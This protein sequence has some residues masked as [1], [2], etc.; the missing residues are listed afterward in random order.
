M[1]PW[2][3]KAK[4]VQVNEIIRLRQDTVSLNS[5][6]QE[7]EEDTKSFV[8]K[9]DTARL[10]DSKIAADNTRLCEDLESARRR[11]AD[12]C[13]H[14]EVSR[15]AA[16]AA[17]HE[18][19]SLQLELASYEKLTY[20]RHAAVNSSSEGTKREACS[21]GSL[22]EA[23]RQRWGRQLG[24]HQ[25]MLSQAET[26]SQHLSV[27]K[28]ERDLSRA[29]WET[30]REEFETLSKEHQIL[31]DDNMKVEEF[32]AEQ[33][34]K[35]KRLEQEIVDMGNQHVEA[36]KMHK[37]VEEVSKQRG[38]VLAMASRDLDRKRDLVYGAIGEFQSLIEAAKMERERNTSTLAAR[39]RDPSEMLPQSLARQAE[40]AYR[41]QRLNACLERTNLENELVDAESWTQ[42]LSH[43]KTVLS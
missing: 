12:L 13:Q 11:T 9:C 7:C 24:M 37:E 42:A 5:D 40:E 8:Q 2:D 38:C 33:R 18:A 23:E 20:E 26:A 30:A 36:C 16:D 3:S 19:Q 41:K 1:A 14:A 35:C 32:L 39:T 31:K 17:R 34:D 22:Q 21:V 6:I 28:A 4:K 15:A 43:H 29:R 10:C 25:E 27:A